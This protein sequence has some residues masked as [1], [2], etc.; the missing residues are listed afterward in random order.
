M[1][2]L[3]ECNQMETDS[4]AM[5]KSLFKEG[6]YFKGVTEILAGECVRR[7][8]FVFSFSLNQDI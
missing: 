5:F 3:K 8:L 6:A 2:I 7:L 1:N 4:D